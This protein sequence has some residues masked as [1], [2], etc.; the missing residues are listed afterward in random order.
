MIIPTIGQLY[1]HIIGY[2]L[3]MYPNYIPSY[4]RIVDHMPIELRP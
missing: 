3:T 4:P 1:P 2:V